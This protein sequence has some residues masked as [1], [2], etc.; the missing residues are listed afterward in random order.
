MR[1]PFAH[2]ISARFFYIRVW[3]V[4]FDSSVCVVNFGTAPCKMLTVESD[5]TRDTICIK[6]LIFV[7]YYI[8]VATHGL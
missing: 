1:T 2:F 5:W 4:S 3:Y 6:V 7:R 8:F